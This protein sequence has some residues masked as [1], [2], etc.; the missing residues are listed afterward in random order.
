[1]R[2]L[3]YIL[4]LLASSAPASREHG[5]S[6]PAHPLV[7]G[8]LPQW[9]L[10]YDPPW[11]MRALVTSGAAKL[12]D[13]VDY[14]QGSVVHARCAVADPNA[15][16]NYAYP[17][18]S[19]VDG[20]ADPPSGT[21]LKGAFHQ[22][23]ELKRLFPHLRVL[24]SLEGKAPA[25]AEA[26]QPANRAA[27]VASCVDMFV[28][29]RLAP[30]MDAPGLFDGFDIDWEYPHAEDAA[31]FVALLA[32]FRRQLDALGAKR[33]LGLTIASGPSPRMD[34]GAD[35]PLIAA[36]VD[37]VGLM[38]YDY[39]GPWAS[40]TGPIAPLYPIGQQGSRQGS[41][42]PDGH[43]NADGTIFG[44]SVDGSVQAYLAAGVPA[45]K[46][47]LGVPFYGNHWEEVAPANDGL[48]QPGSPVHEDRPY[49]TIE[50]LALQSTLHRDARSQ[51]PWLYDG[52]TFWTFDDPVS[53]RFKAAYAASH[54]L[55]GVMAWEL[56]NDSPDGALVK[57]IYAGLS[58]P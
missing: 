43:P 48:Y 23:Q 14:A 37:H 21:G 24:L 45:S 53:A 36:A 35:W 39:N 49:S 22:L 3:V 57:A 41:Q 32:E 1:M 18:E 9:G 47:L 25:F 17:A 28:R 34:S 2:N 7:V 11:F 6:L 31:N 54:R 20:R 56:S 51:T 58:R 13:Q 27:F 40:R 50:S 10:Y 46:L 44:G 16:L 15:D 55:G 29:G 38:N 52:H 5:V 42:P 12:L 30:G 8:Y 26:A 33:R 4:L 19:S